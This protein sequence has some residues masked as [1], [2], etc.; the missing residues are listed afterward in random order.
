M[1]VHLKG[2]HTVTMKLGSGE[3]RIYRY[4]WRGGPKLT[5][6]PG[7][8]EFMKS[9]NEALARLKAPPSG[10]LKYCITKF[11]ESDEFK[12]TAP[13]TRVD[14]LKQIAKIEQAFG[15][16]PLSALGDKRTRGIFKAWRAKLAVS[17][18]RQAQYAW[19]V[20]ARSRRRQGSWA[21]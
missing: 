1:R 16:F 20:L 21:H 5:G 7:T 11:L 14:Y 6:E 4:A 2:V 15:D 18:R 8:P 19:T 12:I 13:R 3:T 17:S 9:Y 10:L